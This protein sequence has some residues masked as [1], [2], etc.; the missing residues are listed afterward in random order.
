MNKT[1]RHVRL[2]T[3][4]SIRE[5]RL[6]QGLTIKEASELS[7][8]AIDRIKRWERKGM[9]HV[10]VLDAWEL[11]NAYHTNIES[12]DPYRTPTNKQIV[13]AIIS[14]ASTVTTLGKV[15]VDLL[16]VI[17]LMK[18]ERF[19]VS[20]LEAFLEGIAASRKPDIENAQAASNSV[21]RIG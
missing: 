4:L 2:S 7:G 3:P 21:R 5:H 9:A 14:G 20:E 16:K 8:I 1:M 11:L 6:L 17:A 18:A 13:E 10:Y 19:A 12:H 15:E